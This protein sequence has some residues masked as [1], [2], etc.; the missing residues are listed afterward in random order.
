[1]VL[2][3]A[4]TGFRAWLDGQWFVGEAN[5]HVAIYQGVPASVLGYRLSHVDLETSLP[6]AD[7]AALPLYAG[8]ADGINANS[9]DDALAI[10]AQMRKDL[11]AQRKTDAATQG[12]GNG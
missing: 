3:A 10:V 1:V 6:A 2:G 8:L 4:A 12:G 7:V 5:A 9:R 11:R